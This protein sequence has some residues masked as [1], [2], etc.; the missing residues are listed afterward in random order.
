MKLAIHMNRSPEALTQWILPLGIVALWEVLSL[1]GVIPSR[2]LPAPTN[3]VAAGWKLL[4]SGD[5]VRNIWIS[6][7]RATAGFAIGG[8]FG[9]ALG[10]A[11]GLSRRSE[12]IFHELARD[13]PVVMPLEKTFWAALFGMVVDRFGIPWLINCDGSE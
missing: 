12:R 11:N 10:L 8:A 2:V 1:A 13:G 5:L 6:F 4:L 7:W 9:F 3:V